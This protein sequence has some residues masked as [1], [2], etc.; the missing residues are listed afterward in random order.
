MMSMQDRINQAVSMIKE[1]QKRG[2]IKSYILT[3]AGVSRASDIPTFRGEDGLWEKYNFEEV[4]TLS[5]WKKNPTKL[6]TFYQDGIDLILNAKPNPGHYSITDLQ[7]NGLGE[8]IITQNA[9]GLHQKAGSENVLEIHGNF[10]KVKC[11][12]C[13]FKATFTEPPTEI[14]PICE[15]GSIL[16]PDVIFYEEQLPMKAIEQAYSIAKNADLAIVVGTSAEVIPAAFIPS[17]SKE[18]NAIVLVFNK[19][20]TSHSLVADVFI[21]GKSEETL[22]LF[23]KK[24]LEK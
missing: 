3:G 21:E 4:A 10:T 23:V 16:R 20:L 15:C 13:D 11:E 7:K 9:D 22:P 6:W 17:Y 24:L 19:E 8:Y 18:N 2:P 5:A 1:L 12:K 14:P